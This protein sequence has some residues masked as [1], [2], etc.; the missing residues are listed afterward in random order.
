MER[1]RRYWKVF[2]LWGPHITLLAVMPIMNLMLALL[3]V[4]ATV[5]SRYRDA[6]TA[7]ALMATN[8]LLGLA[9]LWLMEK[10]RVAIDWVFSRLP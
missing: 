4:D 8:G 5:D 2:D 7:L 6:A 9:T 3:A 10:T 1:L